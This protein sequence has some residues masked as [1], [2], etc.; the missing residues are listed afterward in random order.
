MPFQFL[1]CLSFQIYILKFLN[2]HF[3]S[4]I[5]PEGEEIE[6]QRSP[7]FQSE[8]VRG[9]I[10]NFLKLTYE[11]DFLKRYLGGFL[12]LF[13]LTRIFWSRSITQHW[14][15]FSTRKIIK[16]RAVQLLTDWGGWHLDPLVTAWRVPV[17][18]ASSKQDQL[19]HIQNGWDFTPPPFPPRIS[20]T[21]G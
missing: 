3:R 11:F 2:Y 17:S 18:C 10:Y 7:S 19:L 5:Q 8:S 6:Y 14:D 15:H 9:K 1:C 4:D 20:K 21:R 16:I 13:A 12:R